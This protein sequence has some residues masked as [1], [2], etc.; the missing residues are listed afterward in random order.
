MT[1]KLTPGMLRDLADVCETP[2]PY[3][4]SAEITH[5]PHTGLAILLR[6]EA[7]RRE[8]EA[9]PCVHDWVQEG[10]G[11]RCTKCGVPARG[12]L[13]Q[14]QSPQTG[15]DGSACDPI[16][17][18]EGL[19]SADAELVKRLRQYRGQPFE[20]TECFNGLRDE[21]AERI[22]AQAREIAELKRDQI[23]TERSLVFWEKRA[24][25]AEAKAARLVIQ[26][27][28][29]KIMIGARLDAMGPALREAEVNA[30]WHV[31]NAALSE[32]GHA[33]NG[34]ERGR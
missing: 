12:G 25:V 23:E 27:E 30:A 11:S 29:A 3:A 1:D 18:R 10:A 5:R 15:S 2:L 7:A 17:E 26:M 34:G 31:L 6:E 9:K 16:V 32:A 21:A 33:D 22:E 8:A 24:D 28:R 13:G 19:D 14:T 20:T 4:G